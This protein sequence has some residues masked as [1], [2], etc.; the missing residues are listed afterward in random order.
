MVEMNY[1]SDYV[2]INNGNR[3]SF[4]VGEVY[5]IYAT[6]GARPYFMDLIINGT[7]YYSGYETVKG[8][9][10]TALPAHIKFMDAG[11][12]TNKEL[13]AIKMTGKLP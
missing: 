8:F 13:F 7:S 2:C 11:Y 5:T 12:F 3:K 10:I 1:T 4:T 6:P 9:S